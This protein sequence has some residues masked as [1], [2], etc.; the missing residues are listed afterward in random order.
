[1]DKNIRPRK[2]KTA[3][4]IDVCGERVLY[5]P[6]IDQQPLTP[7]GGRPIG[8]DL[9]GERVFQYDGKALTG[10]VEAANRDLRTVHQA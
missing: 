9:N 10:I 8:E 3:E 1:M 5:Y 7:V 2:K 4:E 6:Y